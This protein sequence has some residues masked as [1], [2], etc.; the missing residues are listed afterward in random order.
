MSDA[1][2]LVEIPALPFA[3][4]SVHLGPSTQMSCRHGRERH[5]GIAI[6]GDVEIIPWATPAS[7]ELKQ[8]DT[9]FVISLSP[10]LLREAAQASGFDADHMVVSNRFH[11]RDVQI[12][13][14]ALAL[15]N[16]MEIGYPCGR[17]YLDS[18]AQALAVHLVHRHSSVSGAARSTN[19]KMP[20][21]KLK[22]L[23]LFIDD[24]LAQDLSLAEI[25]GIAGLSPSHCN[26]LFRAAVGD[27]IHRYVIRR[28][29]E[30]AAWLLQESQLPICQVALETGFAHQSHLALHM[31][32]LLGTT[33]RKL[34]AQSAL[35]AD[36]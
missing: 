6:H 11:T 35:R 31:R 7:W 16:E 33:P 18:M 32:R 36:V 1:P 20:L 24:H 23:L 26:S 25:A 22:Q 27:S 34:R 12:E 2:G 15:K 19:E 3:V 28:R 5:T 14:M 29:V 9:A 8:R 10:R 4:V 13:H 17:L 30:R 21:G